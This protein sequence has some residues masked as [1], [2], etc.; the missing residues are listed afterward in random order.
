[1]PTVVKLLVRNIPVTECV[2]NL[3]PV[4]IITVNKFVMKE[5][6]HLVQP[7]L[8]VLVIVESKVR[9][10]KRTAQIDS[11]E[12]MSFMRM[13]MIDCFIS[14]EFDIPCTEPTPSCHQPCEALLACGHTCSSSC[15]TPPCPACMVV[16]KKT[17]RCGSKTAEVPCSQELLC[18]IKCQEMRDCGRHRCGRRC[19]DGNHPPCNVV[20]LP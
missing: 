12:R 14:V 19:C 4:G 5:T 11:G 20:R 6:V 18:S 8:H 2:E 17:C 9:N 15:H 3:C 13:R 1:M 10:N 16:V 7:S